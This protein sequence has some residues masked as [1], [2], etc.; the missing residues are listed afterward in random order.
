MNTIENSKN[1]R[2]IVLASRKSTESQDGSYAMAVLNKEQFLAEKAENGTAEV[3]LITGT[4]EGNAYVI[5][6]KQFGVLLNKAVSEKWLGKL[7]IFLPGGIFGAFNRMTK[8]ID[9][10]GYG[11]MLKAAEAEAR[12]T[13][14]DGDDIQTAIEE[15]QEEVETE[16]LNVF[17]EGKSSAMGDEEFEVWTDIYYAVKALN[18]TAGVSLDVR[19]A[20]GKE[21]VEG[22]IEA[23]QARRDR[24]EQANAR[25]A[26]L[27]KATRDF[28]TYESEIF[29]NLFS[30]VANK[31]WEACPEV[32]EATASSI[33]NAAIL[34]AFDI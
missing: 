33:D 8:L 11:D 2:L 10:E 22:R 23:A 25:L 32:E 27:G 16:L 4:D 18:A 5:G 19:K 29:M 1:E 14:Q 31:A 24:H 26:K 21:Y 12:K 34:E 30:K 6:L 20:Y 17:A 13:A 3:T 7:Q 9:E 15:A 28:R